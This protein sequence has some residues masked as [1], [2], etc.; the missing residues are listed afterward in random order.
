MRSP[1]VILIVGCSLALGGCHL[2]MYIQPK[3]KSQSE[4]T[5]FENGMGSRLPVEGT[6]EYGK[7][8]EDRV[9]FTGYEADGKLT[10]EMPIQVNEDVVARGKERFE[11]FCSHCHG[12]AGD[13]QGMIAQRGFDL[14]RPVATY[15][16]DRLRNM[17][18]GHFFDVITNGYGT[19]YPQAGRIPPDDRWAIVAYIR[20]LQLS[21][22]ATA[23]QLDNES[24]E[25]VGLA[26]QTTNSRPLFMTPQ[27]TQPDTRLPSVETPIVRPTE[28]GTPT[29]NRGGQR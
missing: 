20:A 28:A 21:Q 26:P 10:R 6:I 3:V 16:T 18:V 4:N 12:Y 1:V 19:M 7:A 2:D 24:R 13:G 9:F 17:P 25:K 14:A 15:H 23:D 8:N 11:I 5:F 29:G 27:A 22:G